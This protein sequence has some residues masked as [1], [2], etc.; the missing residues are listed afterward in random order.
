MWEYAEHG[1][2]T[3]GLHE[4]LQ[5]MGREGWELVSH[6]MTDDIHFMIFKRPAKPKRFTTNDAK[7]DYLINMVVISNHKPEYVAQLEEY[8]MAQP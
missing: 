7:L 2:T 5:S 4:D 8:W 6:R 3:R 1:M